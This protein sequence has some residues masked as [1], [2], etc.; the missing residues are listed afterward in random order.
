MQIT[1]GDLGLRPRPTPCS[2]C[3]K[4]SMVDGAVVPTLVSPVHSLAVA[5]LE[6]VDADARIPLPWRGD[7]RRG[8]DGL[9]PS[10][11]SPASEDRDGN[12]N[13]VAAATAAGA[14]LHAT[15]LP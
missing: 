8:H 14:A 2:A 5:L 6:V 12:A 1:S 15:T 10:M 13:L 4:L 11:V 9:R 3:G 7:E